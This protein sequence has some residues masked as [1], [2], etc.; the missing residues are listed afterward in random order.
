MQK[1]KR[2]KISSE[3]PFGFKKIDMKKVQEERD[4]RFKENEKLY[5]NKIEKY[6]LDI[7]VEEE[8]I[9]NLKCP[10]CKSTKKESNK[11][12]S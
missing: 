1:S 4:A 3:F 8:R 9:E 2:I 5:K 12:F 10:C 7:K 6:E 11:N